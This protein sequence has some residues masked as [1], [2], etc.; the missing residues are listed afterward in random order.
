M[1]IHGNFKTISVEVLLEE[2]LIYGLALVVILVTVIYYVFKF[3][4]DSNKITKLIESAVEDRLN[5]PVS[6]HP[7]VDIN[8]CIGSGA[9]VNSCPEKNILGLVNGKATLI[10]ASECIGHGACLH[11]CPVEAISLVIGTEKRGVDL[12][13]I[14]QDFETNIPGIFIAGELGGMGLIRNCT[15]QGIQAVDFIKSKYLTKKHNFDNDLIIIGSGPA[16]VSASLTAKLNK[17]KFL[18]LE[19]TTLGGTVNS[20]PREKIIMTQPMALPGYGKIKTYETSK[21]QLLEIWTEAFKKN[22]IEIIENSKVEDIQPIDGNGFKILTNNNKEFTS[23]TVLLAIG[24]RGTP[25]KLDVPGEENSSKVFYRLLDP[26]RMENQNILVVG[27]GDSAIESAILLMKNNKVTLSYRKD[28][29]NRAKVK[30][31]ENINKAIIENIL[32]VQFNTNVISISETKVQ[33]KNNM[34][35][36]NYDLPYDFI[37]VFIGGLL[38]N[39]FLNKIGITITKR[40][41]YTVKSY[42]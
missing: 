36:E 15:E 21:Q 41:N 32:D 29:F 30:N 31:R 40:F 18:T 42:R 8:F 25:R 6:L 3:K 27:G 5:E 2:I 11:S 19:Q 1:D 39:A 12:P 16:G 38:P 20:Y 14:N 23:K 22:G 37:Y 7:H 13:Q 28:S 35:D 24:R 33:M 10:K 4:R 17:I 26:E 9:C 34:T